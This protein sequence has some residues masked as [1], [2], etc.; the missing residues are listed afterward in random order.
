[1]CPQRERLNACRSCFEA[2]WPRDAIPKAV[3]EDVD[4]T[5]SPIACQGAVRSS[6]HDG[7]N[8]ATKPGISG[9]W[10]HPLPP[11]TVLTVRVLLRERV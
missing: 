2:V 9:R 11:P 4:T 6:R 3:D 7:T 5:L 1:M 8:A 10:A